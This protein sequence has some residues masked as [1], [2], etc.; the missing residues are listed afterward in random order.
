MNNMLQLILVEKFPVNAE[1]NSVKLANS[2]YTYINRKQ[3]LGKFN[4]HYIHI[5][6]AVKRI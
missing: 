3:T 2:I 5:N 4:S 1:E 6:L